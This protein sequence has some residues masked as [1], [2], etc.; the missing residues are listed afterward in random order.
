M[1]MK[2]KNKNIKFNIKINSKNF[3]IFLFSFCITAFVIGIIF[4]LSI[5][6]ITKEIINSNIDS[7]FTIKNNYNFVHLFINSFKNNFSNLF[8]VWLVGISIIGIPLIFIILFSE[9]FSIGFSVAA[10]INNYK[11]GSILGI[12]TYLFPSKLL[13]LFI[14]FILSFFSLKFSYKLIQLIFF[15]KDISINSYFKKYIKLL[16]YITIL[17]IIVSIFDI[18]VTP[19][20][21][22]IFLKLN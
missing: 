19:F 6:N 13:Y 9:F 5:N 18:Y 8:V 12:F 20:L 15:K 2:L 11:I 21:I 1:K 16:I 14:L 4:Y 7:Y 17:L 10:I 3:I 22:K